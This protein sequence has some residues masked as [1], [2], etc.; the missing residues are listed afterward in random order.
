M[1]NDKF[2]EKISEPISQ[3]NEY[4]VLRKVLKDLTS[5]IDGT[6]Y[7]IENPL[8][9]INGQQ[10][11]EKSSGSFSILIPDTKIIFT[12]LDNISEYDFED[13]VGN[14]I[15]SI[16]TLSEMFEF[17]KKVGNSRRWNHLIEDSLSA[18]QITEEVIR[19]YRVEDSKD[20]LKILVSLITGSINTPDK[21]GP[22]DN[23]LD[24][25]KKRIVQ[26]DGDQTRFVY[27]D[28]KKKRISIQ[29]LAGTGKTELL[30][31][32][33]VNLYTQTKSSIAFTCYS[34]V[35]ANDI[36]VRLPV[37][38]D[39]MKISERSEINDRVKVMSSWGSLYN[40]N[41]GF[42]RYI[43][44]TYKLNFI[45]FNESGLMGFDGVCRS[46]V[47]QLK[48]LQQLGEFEPCFGYVLV[49]EA[50]DFPDSFFEL[51]QLVASEQVILA[52]DI[53]QEIFKRKSETIQNPDFTLNKVYRTDPRNFM[54]S[55][56]LGFGI[57]DKPIIKWLEDDAWKTS[58][59]TIVKNEES[60]NQFYSFSRE[61][62]N[63]FSDIDKETIVPTELRLEEDN[64]SI[65]YSV[66]QII[67]DIRT[68][69][70]NVEPGDIGIVFLSKQNVGYEL[71]NMI[72][73][74]II[75][76]FGWKTQKI[77]ESKN[78]FRRKNKVFISNQNNVKGLE[79]SF[80]IGIVLDKI[81]DDVNVRNT[82]YMM[83]TRSFLTSYLILG[84]LN[85][86]IYLEY[87]PLLEEIITTGTA[88]IKK[89]SSDEVIN[90]EDLKNMVESSLTFEQKVEKVLTDM[91][92]FSSDN[93]KQAKNLVTLLNGDTTATVSE[94]QEI[95]EDNRKHFK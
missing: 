2:Y 64:N 5:E 92:L 75:T 71:A 37:F 89:P 33:L 57:K 67:E 93:L 18:S 43:C 90:E 78:R 41:S 4:L 35:L 1:S 86:Q 59:Y 36:A 83:M 17:K 20:T 73:T 44:A 26:F 13:Y 25:V 39:R 12:H 48:R 91:A 63:R 82:V 32:R 29:G 53:F 34:K 15:D 62:L 7:V 14:Y 80:L 31:H 6:I 38:F 8:Y 54:F 21:G 9:S 72:S 68:K 52:S 94:I 87:N 65:V 77:Y 40:P 84:P 19:N 16:T 69:F 11:E 27:D 22:V 61:P 74:M 51:C 76:D 95:V 10:D 55:Q 46:A 66:K 58:G 79:F 3:S 28:L 85:N 42:Y 81:T 45:N 60:G 47:E 88:K 30:F 56:F 24:A 23:L 49:D 50:Q 70:P